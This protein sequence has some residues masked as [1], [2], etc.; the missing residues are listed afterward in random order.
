MI[1]DLSDKP[2]VKKETPVAKKVKVAKLDGGRHEP[3][4]GDTVIT[5]AQP[6]QPARPGTVRDVIK[7]G[8]Q[9]VLMVQLEGAQYAVEFRADQLKA[10]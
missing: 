2:K 6:G 7:G 4:V 5:V 8:R 10:V 9:L 1:P 3:R